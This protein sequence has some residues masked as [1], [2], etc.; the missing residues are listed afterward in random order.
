MAHHSNS[1]HR[2]PKDDKALSQ[3]IFI[4][5]GLAIIAGGLWF[6]YQ[7]NAPYHPDVSGTE[8]ELYLSTDS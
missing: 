5:V 8:G 1:V 7:D 6:L 2:T 3:A 4:V